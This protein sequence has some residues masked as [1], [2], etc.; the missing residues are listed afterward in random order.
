[1]VGVV[2]AAYSIPQVLLRIPI[3]VW[4]DRLVRRKPLVLAGMVFAS[5]GALGL[6]ISTDPWLLFPARMTAG[7]GA[8]TWVVFTIYFTAYYPAKDTGRAIGL[9]SFVRGGALIVATVSGGFNNRP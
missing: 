8:A 9:L 2:L 7:L 1:M 6:G 3:G 4:A 5:L